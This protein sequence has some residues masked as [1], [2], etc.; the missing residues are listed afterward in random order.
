[1][2]DVFREWYLELI[3]KDKGTQLRDKI[4]YCGFVLK[5]EN[6]EYGIFHYTNS[7]DGFKKIKEEHLDILIKY[8]FTK[9]VDNIVHKRNLRRFNYHK[10]SIEELSQLKKKFD[11]DTHI[12]GIYA[13]DNKKNLQ[14]V[15]KNHVD[16]Y[17]EILIRINKHKSKYQ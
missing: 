15:L 10:K 2:S 17:Y 14:H 5:K 1:M 8:G 16:A 7:G 6:G 3:E 11:V 4:V 13:D 9:G 12:Q